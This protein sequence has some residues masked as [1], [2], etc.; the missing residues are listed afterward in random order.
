MGLVG[1]HTYGRGLTVSTNS[2]YPLKG[3]VPCSMFKGSHYDASDV[4]SHPLGLP[5]YF[6]NT[7]VIDFGHHQLKL[8]IIFPRLTTS[9]AFLECTSPGVPLL[10]DELHTVSS[11][12]SLNHQS[13][14]KRFLDRNS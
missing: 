9:P 4:P 1:P 11:Q 7:A 8:S 3:I 13:V 5:E 10:P 2:V 6:P 14:H 12:P